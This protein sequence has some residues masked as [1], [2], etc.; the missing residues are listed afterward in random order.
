M[1]SLSGLYAASAILVVGGDSD[2][3][4]CGVGKSKRINSVACN[5]SN[6]DAKKIMRVGSV[7]CC[8]G[9]EG[10]VVVVKSE[11]GVVSYDIRAGMSS[12]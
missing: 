2:G 7:L 5:E 9:Q 4:R 8:G 3:F 6:L 10:L 12:Q 11:V 1:K